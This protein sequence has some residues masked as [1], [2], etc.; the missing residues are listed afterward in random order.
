M[1]A[2]IAGGTGMV[3]S[4]VLGRCLQSNDISEV[5]SLVRKS[6]KTNHEK[7]QEV[8]IQDFE[9]YSDHQHLFKDVDVAFFCIG[10]YTGQ[11]K[12]DVFKKITVNYAVSFAEALEKNSPNARICLLSGA[13]ADRSE[14]SRTSFARYKGMAE[15]QIDS[16]NLIFHSLRPGYIYPV[17]PR[18]EPNLMYKITRAL[19]PV[20]KLFG[21]NSSITSEQLAL[22]IF[23]VGLNGADKTILENRDILDYV[24][25]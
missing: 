17:T 14:K 5:V 18:K 12:D 7:L 6:T 19:Y 8:A 13:G 15:N 16:L 10:V 20:I 2:I 25:V 11:V 3:G 1:K 24:K 21:K 23:N 22:G 4:L 9:D